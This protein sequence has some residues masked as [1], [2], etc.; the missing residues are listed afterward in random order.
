M[1]HNENSSLTQPAQIGPGTFVA[2]GGAS[3]VGK[4][5]LIRYARERLA[6]DPRFYFVRRTITRA[7]EATEDHQ[8][9]DNAQFAQLAAAGAFAIDWQAHGLRYGLPRDIDDAIAAN[10]VVVANISR[11]VLPKLRL[12][13]LNVLA[14]E[15]TASRSTLRD[16][17]NARNR[18]TPEQVAERL[19]RT[20]AAADADW[21]RLD[22]DRPLAKS[23]AELVAILESVATAHR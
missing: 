3:G 7:P 18:E 17:L 11:A 13:Y 9:V 12:R 14:I 23:G 2:I 15:V 19:D 22:N 6:A 1:S 10:R 8:S 16:R 21:V 4:D 20:P 5:S